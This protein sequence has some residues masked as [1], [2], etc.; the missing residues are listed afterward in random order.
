MRKKIGEDV[1]PFVSIPKFRLTAV[2]VSKNYVQTNDSNV[3]GGVKTSIDSKGTNK[4]IMDSPIGTKLFR[5]VDA[6]DLVYGKLSNHGRLVLSYIFYHLGFN[7]DYIRLK[8]DSLCEKMGVSRPIISSGIQE[9]ITN[10]LI[11]KKSQSEYWINPYYMFNGSRHKCY[12]E[13]VIE[14]KHQKNANNN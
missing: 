9:L 6:G 3:V 8:Q 13:S 12:D 1:N 5:T 10:F 11:M 2:M 4:V 14:L 7:M